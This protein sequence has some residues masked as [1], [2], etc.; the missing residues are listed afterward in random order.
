MC[1]P[2]RS[3]E[4]VAWGVWLSREE[5]VRPRMKE[6][7][8]GVVPRHPPRKL[9]QRQ[10]WDCKKMN[11]GRLRRS[12]VFHIWH[13]TIKSARRSVAKLSRDTDQSRSLTSVLLVRLPDSQ[14]PQR[15][16]TTPSADYLPSYTFS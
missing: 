1:C 10:S 9:T 8:L 15:L 12:P 4:P 2:I 16:G 3:T 5:G 11:A 6:M 7:G 13:G 14:P